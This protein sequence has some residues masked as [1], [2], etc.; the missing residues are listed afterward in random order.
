MK[1]IRDS[2]MEFIQSEELRKDLCC[3]MQPIRNSIYNEMYPYILI[4]C[5]YI[6]I[7]TFII[8]VNL[9]LLLRVLNNLGSF[10]ISAPNL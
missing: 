6:V 8:G 2:I 7:L 3:I 9:Y 5:I 10:Y 4:I 1:T